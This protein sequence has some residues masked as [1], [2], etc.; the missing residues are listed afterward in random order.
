MLLSA[1]F[2][3]LRIMLVL[4]E[5]VKAA[6]HSDQAKLLSANNQAAAAAAAAALAQNLGLADAY[7]VLGV[8][9]AAT[10]AVIKKQYMRLSL[11]IHPDKCR[12]A[13]A[14]EAFQAVSK[15]AKV[16]QDSSSRQVHTLASLHT[17]HTYSYV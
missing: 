4:K 16:L 15:A 3:V 17:F 7:S 5:A 8:A 13:D 9:S 10:S 1:S 6:A 12:H 11:L 2:Q 14:H